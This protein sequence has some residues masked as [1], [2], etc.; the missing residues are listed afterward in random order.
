MVERP[1]FG[2]G[3]ESFWLGKRLEHMLSLYRGINQSHNGYIEVFVNL[4]WAGIACLTILLLAGYR[5]ATAALQEDPD[6]GKLRL[7][8]FFV[9]VVVNFTEAS[10]KMMAPVWVL[11][12]LAIMSVPRSPAPVA[13]HLKAKRSKAS[14]G[15]GFRGSAS[16][17]DPA[18]TMRF[19]RLVGRRRQNARHDVNLVASELPLKRRG[20]G[21]VASDLQLRVVRESDDSQMP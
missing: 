14:G 17:H 7:A 18:P 6:W 13:S 11:F 15:G 1:A 3:Y 21:P 5:N 16:S 20:A 12:L 2:T 4:G 8:Y 19:R 9:G 10:F